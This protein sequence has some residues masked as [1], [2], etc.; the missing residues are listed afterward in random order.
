MVLKHGHCLY[1]DMQYPQQTL[2]LKA[3]FLGGKGLEKG[4]DHEETNIYQWTENFMSS[5]RMDY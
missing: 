1:F 3:W 5:S 2:V 4:L